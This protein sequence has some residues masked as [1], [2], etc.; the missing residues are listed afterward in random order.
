MAS[1]LCHIIIYKVE[2]GGYD[3]MSYRQLVCSDDSPRGRIVDMNRWLYRLSHNG[4][5][6]FLT[7]L[8]LSGL[9]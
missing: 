5:I 2:E 1:N 3:V 4:K 9:L 6:G 7:K 8:Q